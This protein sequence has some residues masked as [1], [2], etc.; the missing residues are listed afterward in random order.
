MTNP[1]VVSED[2]TG[3]PAGDGCLASAIDLGPWYGTPGTHNYEL[4]ATADG[5]W[6]F[7]RFDW[8]QVQADNYGSVNTF[9]RSKGDKYTTVVR[10]DF[11]CGTGQLIMVVMLLVQ[12]LLV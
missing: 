1:T 5:G 2:G 11:F 6:E 10:D 7:V 3:D 8:T 12:P 4:S 9:S